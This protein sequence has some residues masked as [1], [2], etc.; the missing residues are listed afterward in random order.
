M[1]PMFRRTSLGSS[2]GP[3][4][5]LVAQE[6]ALDLSFNLTLI[7]SV[8]LELKVR[9]V[10]NAVV[11]TLPEA[12]VSPTFALSLSSVNNSR[13]HNFSKRLTKEQE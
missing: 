12:S 2:K 10:E 11:V 1:T 3:L 4:A 7:G 5:A 6:M 8:L 9:W 13:V